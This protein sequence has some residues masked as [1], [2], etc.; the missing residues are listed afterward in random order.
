MFFRP[1]GRRQTVAR[2][3]LLESIVAH[4]FVRTAVILAV[5]NGARDN[6]ATSVW[7]IIF[8]IAHFA[9]IMPDVVSVRFLE[10]LQVYFFRKFRTPESQSI[11]ERNTDTLDE[12]AILHTPAVFQMMLRFESLVKGSHAHGIRDL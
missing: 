12:Q 7:R 3:S 6:F 5:P 9:I 2:E 10:F 1:T 4:V 11:L 8:S